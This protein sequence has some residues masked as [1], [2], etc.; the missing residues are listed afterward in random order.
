MGEGALWGSLCM[1]RGS[2]RAP[3]V[4]RWA[5]KGPMGLCGAPWVDKSAL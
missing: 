3:W 1:G 2:V 5:L 4:G